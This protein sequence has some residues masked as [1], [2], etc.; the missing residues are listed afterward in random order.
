MQLLKEVALTSFHMSRARFQV[1]PA[2]EVK[3]DRLKSAMTEDLFVTD[4]VYKLVASG[5]AFREAYG[6]A[7]EAFFK[8]KA[9]QEAGEGRGHVAV[10]IETL[11]SSAM[12]LVD[13][14]KAVVRRSWPGGLETVEQLRSAGLVTPLE[15]TRETMK[16]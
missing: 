3:E 5:K 15:T 9:V 6:E 14:G 16:R 13:Y 12:S 11:G 2:L 7:K 10:E 4:E 1:L 8:R